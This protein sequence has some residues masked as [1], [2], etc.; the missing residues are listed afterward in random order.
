MTDKSK[1]RM[2][3]SAIK[4]VDPYANDI[5]DLSSHVAFYTF[6]SE[7]NEWEKT[8]VEGAFF[9]YSRI[10][11][12]FH[13]IFINNRLNTNSFVE[14][15]TSDM[16]IQSQPPF[17]LYKNARCRIRGFW[18]YNSKES[19]RIAVLLNKILSD[20]TSSTVQAADNNENKEPKNNVNI[21]KML[22]DAQM[23]YL[24]SHSGQN[25]TEKSGAPVNVIKFFESAKPAIPDIPLS[26]RMLPNTLFV[27]QVEKQQRAITPL[28]QAD[29]R[30]KN[31]PV[32]DHS[33]VQKM[34]SVVTQTHKN[35]NFEVDQITTE[36]KISSNKEVVL[37][38]PTLSRPQNQHM[39]KRSLLQFDSKPALMP[40]T[41]FDKPIK[42][43]S[44]PLQEPLNASQLVQAFTYLIENDEEFVHK[45]HE[46]YLNSF[47][48]S[49]LG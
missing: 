29:L 31:L 12:P 36:L 20:A 41:M 10:A 18:F 3:L 22:S 42:K 19:D 5:V 44:P 46:A 17:L 25:N 11:Q 14:P 39:H 27:D 48:K 7:R 21:F 26:Q 43:E 15:I 6:N 16:E 34:S 4:K 2:N 45:L 9:V 37:T 40:P 23:E 47:T 33:N 49:L 13:S 1:T 35:S 28:K 8:D 24:S 32:E 38:P 30:P